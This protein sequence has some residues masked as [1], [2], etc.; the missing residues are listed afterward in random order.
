MSWEEATAMSPFFHVSFMTSK[1]MDQRGRVGLRCRRWG[2]V[3]TMKGSATNAGSNMSL[4]R[5]QCMEGRI[6]SGRWMM[7]GEVV[8]VVEEEE[9]ASSD[10]MRRRERVAAGTTAMFHWPMLKKMRRSER[11]TPLG[12]WWWWWGGGG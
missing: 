3:S 1:N 7:G 4:T 12:M 9:E 6:G 2:G 8:V 10:A 11:R 5:P